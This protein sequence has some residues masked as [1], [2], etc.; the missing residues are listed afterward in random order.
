MKV[1]LSYQGKKLINYSKNKY[2]FLKNTF[3]LKSKEK[4][5][6]RSICF[7]MYGIWK[8]ENE[9]KQLILLNLN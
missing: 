2:K 8:Y 5:H 1:R 9:H 4:D 6:F 7:F 3:K